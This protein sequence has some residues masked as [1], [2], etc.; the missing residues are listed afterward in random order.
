MRVR[1]MRNQLGS[2]RKSKYFF[3]RALCIAIVVIA[4][5][6]SKSTK[7]SN[8]VIAPDAPPSATVD[9]L[10]FNVHTDLAPETTAVPTTL[11]PTIVDTTPINTAAIDTVATPT[12]AP[13]PSTPTPTPA[14]I[15]APAPTPA[16][17]PAPVPVPAPT[18]PP[19][20]PT[21]KPT[22]APKPIPTSPPPTQQAIPAPVTAPTPKPTKAPKPPKS[23]TTKAP[24]T[25]TIKPLPAQDSKCTKKVGT[26]I[27]HP[28]GSTATC[29]TVGKKRLWKIRRS[30]PTTVATVA[31]PTPGFDGTTI[32]LGVLTTTTNPTW[33]QYG[34]AQLAS[35]EAHVAAINKRGGI[36][37][38]YKIELIISDTNY[39]A[40]RSVAE[41]N[42]N[43]TKVAGYLSILGTPSVDAVLPLLQADG[44][45]ASPGS[46]EA[47]WATVPQLLPLANSY[48][49]QA[50]NGISYFVENN[51]GA[52]VCAVSISN[53]Y[54]ETGSEGFRFAQSKIGFTAGPVVNVAAEEANFNGVADQLKGA[55]CQGVLVTTAPSQTVALALAAKAIDFNPRWLIMG[56]SFSDKA[57][58]AQTSPIF[59]Q[60]AW[61]LGDGGAWGDP[62]IPGM[63]TLKNELIASN[64]RFWTE[65]PDTGLTY[66]FVQALVWEKVL[67]RA[68]AKADFSR[69]SILAATKEIGVV[70][71]LGLTSAIDYSQSVRLSN[72]KTTIFSVD[73]SYR[74]AIKVLVAGY[75]S[76]AAQAY[77]K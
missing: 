69:A 54:G 53:T 32:R 51:R 74:Q 46:Q 72:A 77:R 61:I 2:N 63:A 62:T 39:E 68:A 28:D 56:T 24:T 9:A 8:D 57:I 25:T 44:I 15:P 41:Y 29:E 20:P 26:V 35:F 10:P 6:C 50:I 30:A 48:Q 27:T 65:N 55:N 12:L 58:N 31:A 40:T 14:P 45:V 5:G 43:K 36:A 73:A 37:G 13:I 7:T 33:G 49:I 34:K 3:V 70:D 47:R 4:T 66:G 19:L 18:L 52:T 76:A 11:P 75:S 1:N 67:E 23:T 17:V 71:T 22:R 64:N 59:E 38:K 16:P 60:S 42:A 21:P